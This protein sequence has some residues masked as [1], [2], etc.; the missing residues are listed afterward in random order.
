MRTKVTQ[1]AYDAFLA[2]KPD[3]K[4]IWQ[5]AL[6]IIS[7]EHWKVIKNDFPYDAMNLARHDL[8]IPKFQRVSFK[9]LSPEEYADFLFALDLLERQYSYY[10]LN[11]SQFK[12]V[13]DYIHVHL[14]RDSGYR[15]EN[16]TL[17]VIEKQRT[18]TLIDEYVKYFNSLNLG[19]SG[20]IHPTT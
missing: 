15:P 20:N 13:Q 2:T 14:I 17:T 9:E 12:T 19:I 16:D 6:P 7:T 11:C 18:P 10:R 5:N 1:D 8:L 4:A 3:M